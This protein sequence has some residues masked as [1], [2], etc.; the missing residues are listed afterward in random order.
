MKLFQNLFPIDSILIKLLT[1]KFKI[2]YFPMAR[3]FQAHQI[4]ISTAVWDPKYWTY[5]L[6]KNSSVTGISEKV[7]SPIYVEQYCCKYCLYKDRVPNCPFIRDYRK[8]LDSI[9]FEGYLM[10]EFQRIAAEVK[11]IN[12]YENEPEIILL[13]Y[14]TPDNPCSE[15]AAL[16]DYFK[17]HNIELSE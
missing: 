12:N 15:R 11:Q 17:S 6:N 1:M 9:D 10:P 5:G 8:Y 2:S 14:E 3:H 7:L 16:I 13:V 4:G